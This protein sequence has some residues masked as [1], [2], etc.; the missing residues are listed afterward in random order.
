VDNNDRSG[1]EDITKEH[2]RL[3][4][5]NCKRCAYLDAQETKR[6]SSC[7][8]SKGNKECPASELQIV[9]VGKAYRYAQHVLAARGNRDADAEARIL[10]TVAKQSTAFQERFYAALENPSEILE[11]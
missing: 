6:F 7:H 10:A 1:T 5:T 3:Y 4:S 2:L 9:I 8:Y 11:R